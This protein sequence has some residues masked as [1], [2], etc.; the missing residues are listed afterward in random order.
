MDASEGFALLAGLTLTAAMIPQQVRTIRLLCLLGGLFAL[1]ALVAA[2]RDW[3]WLVL[4][5]A[6]TVLNA[7][8]L[9]E[10]HR[11][12]WSGA[13]NAEERELFAHVM[14]I[15]DPPQSGSPARS[16]DVTQCVGGRDLNRT[17]P[18]R[19]FADLRCQRT[20]RHRT[21]WPDRQ[22]MRRRRVSRRNQSPVGREC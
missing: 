15:E 8:R 5:G 6:L 12:A 13:M 14:R 7:V 3:A 16:D 1:T 20:C 2:G 18:A 19:S 4:V 9:I 11:R 10:L 17:G 21:Q 22:R